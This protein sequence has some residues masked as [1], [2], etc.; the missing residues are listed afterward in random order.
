MQISQAL[1]QGH[2]IL[3]SH[4]IEDA[5]R[6]AEWL[7]ADLFHE[8]TAYLIAHFPEE[9]ASRTEADYFEKIRL[10]SQRQPLQYL[11]G[12]EEFCGSKF[13]V[14]PAVLIPRL[15]TELL[16]AEALRRLDSTCT[17]ITD[18]GTGSGCIAIAIAKVRPRLNVYAVDISAEAL[19]VARRNANRLEVFNID[20]LQGDLLTPLESRLVKGQLD[21]IV[22]NPPYVADGELEE[23]QPEVRDW[24]PRIALTAGLSGTAIFER[25]IPEAFSWLRPEGWFLAEIGY[26]LK[27]R[28]LAL[29]HAGWVVEPIFNDQSGIPRVVIARKR[30]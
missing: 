25:L 15:E 16:V 29:F 13:E 18:V 24:E 5:R 7:L 10:R 19:A 26:G 12:Y 9:L 11:L 14:N 3:I 20:F 8:S 28:V 27:E 6:H 17:T 23:L 1:Q 21:C 2:Q 4:G 22:S 30:K